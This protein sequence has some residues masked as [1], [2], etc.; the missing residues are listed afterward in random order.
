ME[1]VEKCFLAK[2]TLETTTVKVVYTVVD[3]SVDNLVTCGIK[4]EIAQAK[5]SN[6]LNIGDTNSYPQVFE[7]G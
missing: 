1:T 3:N 6:S 4:V 5:A 2:Q 7:H